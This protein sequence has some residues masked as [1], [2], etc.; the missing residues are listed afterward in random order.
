MNG[1]KVTFN[2]L[3]IF[4]NNQP[5]YTD[6]TIGQD[7]REFNIPK[8]PAHGNLKFKL[9]N[10]IIYL[11]SN[12]YNFYRLKSVK[13]KWYTHVLAITYNR[14]KNTNAAVDLKLYTRSQINH[15]ATLR[16]IKTCRKIYL[17]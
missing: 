11:T 17:I 6:I 5:W 13:N 2:E 9:Q 10:S 12:C 8:D 7:P 16:F 14:P 3:C 4:W 1:K 15:P